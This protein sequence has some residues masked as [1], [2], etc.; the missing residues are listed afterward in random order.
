MLRAYIHDLRRHGK[1][2]LVRH[3][4]RI[5]QRL[6]KIKS[7]HQEPEK[8]VNALPALVGMGTALAG[9]S[10]PWLFEA[11]NDM[12]QIEAKRMSTTHFGLDFFKNM[13]V[14]GRSTDESLPPTQNGHPNPFLKGSQQLLSSIQS[15]TTQ[16]LHGM[17]SNLPSSAP[18]LDRLSKGSAFTIT[19]GGNQSLSYLHAELSFLMALVDI[20]DRLRHVPKANRQS[21]LFAE[22]S[23][24][25]HNLPANICMPFWCNDEHHYKA[26]RI[27][28]GDSVVLNSADRVPFLICVE[29]LRED[30][31][32]EA[33]KACMQT[34]LPTNGDAQVLSPVTPPPVAMVTESKVNR[35]R[36]QAST[37]AD[38]S[39]DSLPENVT[40]DFHS[41]IQQ[42]RISAL[43]FQ[44]KDLSPLFVEAL[45][46]EDITEKLRTAAIM[47]AQLYQ[48]QQGKAHPV[49][50]PSPTKSRSMFSLAS[51]SQSS[52]GHFEV[53]R[54]NIIKEML[55]MEELRAKLMQKSRE[56]SVSADVG[57]P[58][59]DL[60]DK[61]QEQEL[62]DR[63]LKDQSDDP[64]GIHFLL[65]G[66]GL[67]L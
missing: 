17:A 64:S 46:L 14:L 5:Y 61:D 40:V 57:D 29:I 66:G 56:N 12:I 35:F 9:I 47:L 60:L 18:S 51:N 23:L 55:Q 54:N 4:Q 38:S 48:Q 25:N 52:G 28:P 27:P 37:P 7:E 3:A 67:V 22:L 1:H 58:R 39:N 62:Y 31:S 44:E 8:I 32:V 41:Q 30:K 2:S 33:V 63:F 42:R 50:Q 49:P 43:Q 45:S 34:T 53:I 20:G 15:S 19:Q 11:S 26:L 6:Q 24:I 10:T 65:F 16:L 13:H 36:S 59:E 21:S